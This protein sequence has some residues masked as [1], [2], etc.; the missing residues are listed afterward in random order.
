M[1]HQ[2]EVWIGKMKDEA[3]EEQLTI[4]RVRGMRH[5]WTQFPDL[6]LNED[7]IRKKNEIFERAVRF[8]N[9]SVIEA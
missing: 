2:S 8:V 4:E 9:L 7:E 1:A 5:G 3:M 6:F